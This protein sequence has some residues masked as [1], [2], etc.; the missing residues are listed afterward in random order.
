MITILT[1]RAAILPPSET[2]I[3]NQIVELRKSCRVL[4]SGL[5]EVAGAEPGELPL[6]GNSVPERVARLVFRRFGYSRRLSRLVR[7][8]KVDLVHVHFLSDLE[9]I[10]KFA[11]R[12]RLPLVVTAHGADVTILAARN[13]YTSSRGYWRSIGSVS[14]FVAVSHFIARNLETL[15]IDRSLIS[16]IP[17]GIPISPTYSSISRDIDLLFVGRLVEKKGVSD[18]IRAAGLLRTSYPQLRFVIAGTGP[19]QPSLRALTETIGLSVEFVGSVLPEQRDDLMRRAKIFIAPSKRAP[20]GDSEG[21][22]MVFL[23]AALHG[24]VP[25]AYVHGGVT[26]SVGDG[27]VLVPEGSIS[28][29]SSAISDLLGDDPLRLEISRY[30]RDRVITTFDIEECT[31]GLSALFVQVALDS[32]ST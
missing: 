27:G 15:G 13:R 6:F 10:A 14:R 17:I 16:V 1:W 23:E 18:A 25:V 19:E 20:S 5:W 30:A 24:A 3:R 31:K 21:F 2:F 8:S 4:L 12:H 22:G 28:A 26:E 9:G 7:E 11:R 32:R 29:L